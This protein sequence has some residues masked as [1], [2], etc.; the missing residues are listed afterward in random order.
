MKT[1]QV[2][3]ATLAAAS[4]GI[5]A[6]ATATNEDDLYTD[7]IIKL[8]SV[9]VKSE[10][11]PKIGLTQKYFAVVTIPTETND[12]KLSE[13]DVIVQAAHLNVRAMNLPTNHPSKRLVVKQAKEFTKAVDIIGQHRATGTPD[14]DFC[15]PTI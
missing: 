6:L 14:L 5:S 11:K 3:A 10:F 15:D 4:M 8:K 1:G 13:L 12:I 9:C 7:Q 2:I